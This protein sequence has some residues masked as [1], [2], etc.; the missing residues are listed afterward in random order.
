MRYN[1]SD[2]FQKRRLLTTYVSV[3][4]SISLVLFFVGILSILLINSDKVANHFK[5]QIA[6]TIFFNDNAKPIEIKQLKKSIIIK[7]ETKHIDYISKKDA[8]L[9]HSKDIGED[10]MDFLGYN[11]LLNSINVYFNSD[12]V[13][14][15]F[16]ETVKTNFEQKSF[17]N[18]VFYDE[19]LFELLNDNINKISKW[20]IILSAIFIIIAVLL[21]NSSIRLSI[22]SKKLIIKTMQLVGAKKSFIRKPFIIKYI[23]LGFYGSFISISF[24]LFLIYNLNLKFPELKL[25]ENPEELILISFFIFISCVIITGLSAFFATQ[26]LLNLKTNSIQ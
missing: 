7:K 18:E 6:L 21:I 8:A 15:L 2:E 11:P 1:S 13:T 5:E 9:N 19:P 14:P 22:F 12:Y 20:M 24:L 23:L 10:F 3:V 26:K 4:I 17:I 16:L 25:L